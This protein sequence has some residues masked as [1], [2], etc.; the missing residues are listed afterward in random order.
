MASLSSFLNPVGQAVGGLFK[1]AVASPAAGGDG[2]DTLRSPGDI[3]GY[4]SNTPG[5]Q[6]QPTGFGADPRF[7][8]TGSPAPQQQAPQSQPMGY[9]FSLSNMGG[10]A[11]SQGLMNPEQF[12]ASNIDPNTGM[13]D[14]N[15]IRNYYAPNQDVLSQYQNALDAVNKRGQEAGQEI[16]RQNQ[17]AQTQLGTLPGLYAQNYQGFVEPQLQA[18]QQG[19]S[20]QI[21]AQSGGQQ[22][23]DNGSIAA[24]KAAIGSNQAS[25]ASLVP[26]LQAGATERMQAQQGSLGENLASLQ[27]QQ[28]AQKNSYLQQLSQQGAAAQDNASQRNAQTQAQN[29]QYNAQLAQQAAAANAQARQQAAQQNAQTQASFQQ[30]GAVTPAD[31]F[32]AQVSQGGVPSL[33]PNG[34]VSV[35]APPSPQSLL[36][37]MA[38]QYQ[39]QQGAINSAAGSHYALDQNLVGQIHSNPRTEKAYQEAFSAFSGASDPASIQTAIANLHKKYPNYARSISLALAAAHAPQAADFAS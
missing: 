11:A 28:N 14:V 17:F 15:A 4:T 29:A 32:K 24:L 12:A 30:Q 10:G 16:G 3:P 6:V 34:S 27:A 31:V 8:T 39:P 19:V 5:G 9:D 37:G 13:V 7:A 1:R 36:R 33:G 26:L 23:N 2:S 25:R 35:G 21:A 38:E 22:F 20:Q 18:A